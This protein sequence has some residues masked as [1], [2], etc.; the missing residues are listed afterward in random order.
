MT[1]LETDPAGIFDGHNDWAWRIREN[2]SGT[3]E[4]L[5][6][7]PGGDTDINRL[8]S[9][10]VVAQFW[11]VYV[12]DTL[13]GADAVQATLEQIDWVYRLVARYPETFMFSRTA[14]DV[15]ASIATGRIASLLGAEGAH[16]INGS[17]A[18]LR[19]FAR[20]G[21]RYLTLTHVHNTDW[22][23]SATDLAAHAGLTAR[24][25]EYIHELNRL[26]MLV[27]LSHVS[28]ATMHAALEASTSPVIFSHSS[29]RAVTD[30]PRNVPDDVLER[31]SEN[32]GVV[33]ITF[34][35]EFVSSAYAQWDNG[36]RMH[37]APAV[38]IQHVADH[39]DHARRVAGIGHI[40]IGGDFDG[41]S[42]HP[43]G[44][45]SVDRYPALLAELGRRGWSSRELGALGGG[46]ILRVLRGTDDAFQNAGST[47]PQLR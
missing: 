46:N 13:T 25:V 3:V 30:H 44:L 6:D 24:G 38:T 8:R 19:M 43:R 9:G 7:L 47:C 34:V 29:C 31:L 27:D 41:T 2:D 1:W 4:G 26:G 10:G 35:P 40:G 37:P 11:S 5:H 14:Q 15:E 33:M 28:V 39:I 45:G 23:D 32:G 21:V 16:S 42:V 12:D 20:L 18:V 22:A 36:G 17:P